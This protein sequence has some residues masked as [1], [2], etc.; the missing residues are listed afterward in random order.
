MYIFRFSYVQICIQ[1]LDPF[2]I[3]NT[4]T[5]KKSIP[6]RLQRKLHCCKNALRNFGWQFSHELVSL[7]LWEIKDFVG[8]G[9]WDPRMEMWHKWSLNPGI[10][11][12]TL[13]KENQTQSFMNVKRKPTKRWILSSIKCTCNLCNEFVPVQ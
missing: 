10:F 11:W 1:K 4:F 12:K 3:A 13:D 6:L 8:S 2:H 5:S 9:T 7:D